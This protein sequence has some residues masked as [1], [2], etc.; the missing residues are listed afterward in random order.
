LEGHAN[1]RG[2]SFGQRVS[3]VPTQINFE[4]SLGIDLLRKRQAFPRRTL[5]VEDEGPRIGSNSIPK[6]FYDKMHAADVAVV[7][8]SMEFRVQRIAHEYVIEMTKEF[9]DAHPDDGWEMFV[10]YLTQSL[11]RVHKRLGLE[12]YKLVAS[13]MEDALLRQY[14]HGDTSGHEAWIVAMLR[15]YYDP[16][17][18]YQLE[19]QANK[20]VFRGGYDEV[21]EWA[22]ERSISHERISD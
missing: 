14:N 1:H 21:L 9:L 16:M 22:I 5:V 6:K 12:N 11:V 3:G 18:A 2:S 19:K 13:L 17:Y 20:I 7:E 15:D 10:D 8:T 4:N